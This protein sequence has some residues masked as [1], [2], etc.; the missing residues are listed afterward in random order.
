MFE[1]TKLEAPL[2]YNSG[3]PKVWFHAV[4]ILAKAAGRDAYT[5]KYVKPE[6]TKKPLKGVKV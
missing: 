4:G 3:S 6:P 1:G 2:A 5:A